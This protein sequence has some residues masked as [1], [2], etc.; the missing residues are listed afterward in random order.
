MNENKQVNEVVVT[1][2]PE[3][4]Y[5][6]ATLAFIFTNLSFIFW[7]NLMGFLGDGAG[8]AIGAIQC[9][10]F[11]GYIC[12]SIIL[13][14]KGLAFEGNVFMVFASF[15]GGVGGLTNIIGAVAH[16]VGMPF[17]NAVPGICWLLCGVFLIAI[18]P[19]TRTAPKAGF[20]FYIFGG[21]GLIFMG[22]LT[23]GVL[24]GSVWTQIIAWSLF[25]AG[26][27]GLFVTISTMNGLG[28]VA[29]M[30]P[31]GKPFFKE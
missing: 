19:G 7:A 29:N 2:T 22:L 17:S 23:L 8:L 27:C 28:G 13:L 10:V 26:V 5:P 20:L 4:G 21:V 11:G 6:G 15:F 3:F 18:L 24:G 14:K 16:F 30:P 25:G 31:L 9:G 1:A 12:G